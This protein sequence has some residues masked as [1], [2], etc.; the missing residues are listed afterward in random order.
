M[1]W[2]SSFLC[3]ICR[4]S[5]HFG[6]TYDTKLAQSGSLVIIKI[7]SPGSLVK[8]Q[9]VYKWVPRSLS[10]TV[11]DASQV[12]VSEVTQVGTEMLRDRDE[13]IAERCNFVFHYAYD[14][15][16]AKWTLQKISR[17]GKTF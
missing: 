14:T 15:S 6:P 9:K 4:N 11:E 7:I 12:N 10:K 1:P 13:L 3:E 16:A 17:I 5:W 8:C 2:L